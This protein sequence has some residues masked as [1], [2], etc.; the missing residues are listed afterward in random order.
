MTYF[1]TPYAAASAL[2][3]VLAVAVALVARPRRAR[4]GAASLIWF[5]AAV[6]E[7]SLGSAFEYGAVGIPAKVFWS[8]IEYLGTV[9]SPVFILLF[10][11]EYNRLEQWLT[12]RRVALLFVVPLVTLALAATNGRHGLIWSGFAPSPV[13]DN[14]LVY[15]HGPAYWVGLF[16][17]TYLL[18]LLTTGLLVRATL[19]FPL[20]YRR[21]S[22]VILAG[23]LVPWVGN[24]VYNLGLSPVPGLDLTPFLL[25]ASGLA[26][27]WG[28]FGFS[29]F[30]LAPIARDA[31]VEAMSDGV[32]VLDTKDRVLDLNPAA[33]HLLGLAADV[34]LGRPVGEVLSAWPILRA[35]L[36]T[37]GVSWAERVELP[38][39]RPGGDFWEMDVSPVRDRRGRDTGRLVVVRD[40]TARK[41]DE[42]RLQQAHGRLLA[43]VREI[44]ALQDE[45]RDQAIRDSLTGLYN[46]RYLDRALKRELVRAAHDR[47]P[48]SVVVIDLDHFKAVND[49]FGHGGGDA[50]LKAFGGLLN[51][52]TRQGDVVCRYGG[53]EFVVILPG[54][55]PEAACQRAEEWRA[56]LDA[57]R[58]PHVGWSIRATLSAGV[59]SY[60]ERG[61]TGESLLRAADHALY[62][63]K[64]EGRNRVRLAEAAAL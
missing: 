13:G 36:R 41:Q 39:A 38:P 26:F 27:A 63:A 64:A 33:R 57:L 21:Q 53:E 22:Q 56:D 6:A 42:A 5:M 43:Q 55:S 49:T 30:D 60:P 10:A 16:G 47:T 51:A 25:L 19:R 9:S 54:T 32:L 44:E 58:V 23:G 4:P 52:G 35:V 11:L 7:W 40:I 18:L 17:Y 37:A 3:A 15:R 61:E 20:P 24:L 8:K 29:L 14:L 28:I 48:F 50:L 34:A 59:A 12:P 45:L 31:L 46:R 62:A 1:I 2:T